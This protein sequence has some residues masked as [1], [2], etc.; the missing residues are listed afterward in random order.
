MR[1]TQNPASG[2][3]PVFSLE[4]VSFGYEN[5]IL[6]DVSLALY[7]GQ[8]IGLAGP[9]GAGKTSLFRCVTG[10][11]SIWSGKIYFYGKEIRG[12]E[13]FRQLR[14]KVGF[15]LQDAENQLFFPEVLEDLTFGP[16]N[17][18]LS[19][20]AARE[21]ALFAL[22][23]V[24]LDGYE[25]RLSHTLSGGEKKLCALAAILAMRP[26]ALLLDEPDNALDEK[27]TDRLAQLIRT[28]PCAKIVISH[29]R[30]FLRRVCRDI[31][32]LRAGSLHKDTNFQAAQ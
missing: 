25:R 29:E 11:S 12:E 5:P 3:L 16:L 14:R 30:S 4:N 28:L 27:A 10:L 21:A 13:D 15:V 1:E 31:L 22:R 7:P 6:R 26:E 2:N 18:G 24:G 9:N 32:V 19:P 23:L 17:L 20:E 8:T